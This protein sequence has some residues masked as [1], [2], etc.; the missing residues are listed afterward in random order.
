MKDPRTVVISVVKNEVTENKFEHFWKEMAANSPNL[1]PLG[2]TPQRKYDYYSYN[3]L[4]PK[5]F[6]KVDGDKIEGVKESE[7]YKINPSWITLY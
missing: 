2:E 1:N 4:E 5:R 6:F 3:I 7:W